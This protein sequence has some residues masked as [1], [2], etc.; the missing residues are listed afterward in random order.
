MKTTRSVSDPYNRLQRLIALRWVAVLAELALV[1]LTREWLASGTPLLPI[2]AICMAQ[3]G[4][5]LASLAFGLRR[6]GTARPL[7]EGQL[8]A[9]LLFDVGA[10][11]GIAY[12]AGGST[13]PLISLYLLWI[14]VGAAML[15]ARRA[16]TLAA[17]SIAAY[18]LVN[19]VHS[20][21][22]IHDHEK[23]LEIHLIGMWLI[24]VFSA[25][26]I[27]WSV[28][29]LMAAVRRRDAE[30]AAAREAALRSE[31]VLALGNLAAGAAH[32]LGTPLATMAVLAG[33]ILDDP[34]L[35]PGLRADMD[36][37]RAQVQACK[38]IITQLAAQAG[39]SRA[40]SLRWMPLDIWL[41]ELLER[42]QV[43]RPR[44]QP[45]VRLEGTQP[46]P[47]LALDATLGQALLNLFNNAAD[48]SPEQV[49]IVA[50]W[51]DTPVGGARAGAPLA[52]MAL[53]AGPGADA[54]AG[55][56]SLQV[57]D[58]GPGIA[59]QVQERLGLDPVST[60]QDGMGMGVMLAY[61][62][63]ERSGGRLEFAARAGGGTL[64]EVCIP[65][66]G[67]RGPAG[68]AP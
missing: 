40:E 3:V 39:S 42:W 38:N 56:F 57:M 22:H 51:S 66:A 31:R 13:N 6:D 53:S 25:V 20:E 59:K 54:D 15:D 11:T 65:L 45:Q 28:I 24:F 8:F 35:P 47:M 14:A 17:L 26:T 7:S 49:Q 48:A 19:F 68:A 52:P 46:G 41:G 1:V 21:V 43:Q 32:E 61:A 30:L 58:R 27:C 12:L 60:R 67:L 2:L 16:T 64:A 33:E 29:R 23:A 37:L 4:L 62:A 5:N 10:L 44:V 18:S 34:Q 36:L 50:R 63:I 55:V 9:Q